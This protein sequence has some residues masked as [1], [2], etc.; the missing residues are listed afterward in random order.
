MLA[1]AAQR[2]CGCPIPGGVQGQD[3]WGPGQ[4]GLV[5]DQEVGGRGLEPDDPWGPFQ[6]K[7]FDDSMILV[8]LKTCVVLTLFQQQNTQYHYIRCRTCMQTH[9]YACTEKHKLSP[10]CSKS[11]CPQQY[12]QMP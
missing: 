4:P 7:S 12:Q 10:L 8:V 2:G 1:Q 5:P 9:A 3:G 6:P 11:N